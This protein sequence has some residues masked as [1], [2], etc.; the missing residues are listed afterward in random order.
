[1]KTAILVDGGFFIKR[2]RSLMGNNPPDKVAKDLHE[3]CL[4]HVSQKNNSDNTSILYRILFYDCA[5]IEKKVHNPVTKKSYDFSR[6]SEYLFRRTFHQELKKLR[7]V[8]LRLGKLADQ[9]GW[10]I[11]P[12]QTKNLLNGVIKISDL[13]ENDVVYEVRQKGVDMKIG[14]DIASLAYKKLVDQIILIAGDSDFV[15]AAKLA[16]REGIDFILDPMWNPINPD[17][18][19]HIDGLKSICKKS[20]KK[21]L[22]AVSA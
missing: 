14:L 20:V 5:P 10:I 18:H 9:G 7:K 11:K 8:A 21:D 15:P 19:E 13:Q 17:L 16:R 2:Y 4:Q 3:I 22:V 6:S 12:E 1:M